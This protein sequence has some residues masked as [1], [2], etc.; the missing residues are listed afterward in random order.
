MRIPAM[1]ITSENI[2]KI[3]SDSFAAGA[4]LFLSKPFTRQQLQ[5]TL[6][7]LLINN[8]TVKKEAA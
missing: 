6:R 3:I 2:S 8:G 4:I 1:M 5:T 7:M